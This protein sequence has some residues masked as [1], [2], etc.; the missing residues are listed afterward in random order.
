MGPITGTTTSRL[1][2]AAHMTMSTFNHSPM[3]KSSPFVLNRQPT[4][5]TKM[6]RAHYGR[7]ISMRLCTF[8]S[9]LSCQLSLNHPQSR[10][11]RRP[12]T[13]IPFS[14]TPFCPPPTPPTAPRPLPNSQ[15]C[16]WP[17]RPPHLQPRIRV[18]RSRGG[19]GKFVCYEP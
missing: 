1:H 11:I 9:S 4:K 13:Y 10:G 7:I 18:R 15:Y 19:N 16:N 3:A 17:L 2:T 14:P 8:L 12:Q 5:E 6:P